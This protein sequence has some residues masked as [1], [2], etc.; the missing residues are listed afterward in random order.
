[1][2]LCDEVIN[3]GFEVFEEVYE[4]KEGEGVIMKFCRMSLIL[5]DIFVEV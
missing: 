1:M 2:C 4:G 3:F 5:V